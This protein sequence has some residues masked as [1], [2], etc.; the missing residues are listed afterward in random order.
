MLF[1]HWEQVPDP[2]ELGDDWDINIRWLIAVMDDD[3]HRSLAFAAGCLDYFYANNGR[4]TDKQC[5]ALQR[6][7]DKVYKQYQHGLLQCQAAP[8]DEPALT[9]E[10]SD[11]ER[12]KPN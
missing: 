12:S 2:A 9:L 8:V 4:L 5:N 1:K 7:F 10:V 11:A 3:R 6:I